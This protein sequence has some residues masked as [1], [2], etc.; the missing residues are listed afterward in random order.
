[1]PND[2]FVWSESKNPIAGFSHSSLPVV[3]FD[4]VWSKFQ[5]TH[6]ACTTHGGERTLHVWPQYSTQHQCGWYVRVHSI[7]LSPF[8]TNKSYMPVALNQ[9]LTLNFQYAFTAAATDPDTQTL[10][11]VYVGWGSPIKLASW[12]ASS[13]QTACNMTGITCNSR[14][15]VVSL[16][17]YD[18]PTGTFDSLLF[19][20]T[21]LS[22]VALVHQDLI[23]SV[24]AQIFLLTSLQMLRISNNLLAGS[25]PPCLSALLNLTVLEMNSNQLTGPI[26]PQISTLV[27]LNQLQLGNNK[28]AGALPASLL[29]L[30]ALVNFYAPFNALMG[31]IPA[32]YS[33]LQHLTSLFLASNSLTSIIPAQL[34]SISNLSLSVNNNQAMCGPPLMYGS[35]INTNIGQDCPD[36]S[37]SKSVTGKKLWTFVYKMKCNLCSFK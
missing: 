35:Q 33:A 18:I 15:E 28:F 37:H 7:K 31:S 25:L 23:R 20:L 19:T 14:A 29:S 24:P 32:E 21:A 22:S 13:G 1:M 6:V 30:N 11:N 34:T 3:K 36:P 27:L 4:V 10:N 8:K 5:H 17:F 9:S 12:A 26:P 16:S 2:V